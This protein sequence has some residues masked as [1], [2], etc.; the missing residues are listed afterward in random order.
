MVHAGAV[1]F[2]NACMIM[3]NECKYCNKLK[4]KHENQ[5]SDYILR[6]DGDR[7]IKF[8]GMS[9]DPGNEKLLFFNKTIIKYQGVR[10]L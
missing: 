5:C 1:A 9:E 6:K 3:N 2:T 8:H 7:I 4:R 10:I